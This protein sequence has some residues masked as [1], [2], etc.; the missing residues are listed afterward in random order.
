VKTI[1]D[2]HPN[3]SIVDI[4]F[5]DWM[6]NRSSSSDKP[7]DFAAIADEDKKAWMFIS[8]DTLGRIIINSVSKKLIMMVASKH[9]IIDPSK[10]IGPVFNNRFTSIS[11][12][13]Q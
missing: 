11:C 7:D 9:I 8:I 5:C 6:A 2:H 13:F 4:K 12:R 3:A 10:N 1:K